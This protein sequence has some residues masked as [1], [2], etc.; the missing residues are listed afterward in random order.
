MTASNAATADPALPAAP[1]KPVAGGRRAPEQVRFLSQAI[2]L[3]E[4][5]PPRA[6]R[7]AVAFGTV[8][9]VGAVAWAGATHVEK[10][11]PTTG[12]ILPS[13]M[14]QSVQHLEGGIVQQLLVIEGDL[15]DQGQVV[16][17]LDPTGARGELD[18]LR[19]RE[20]GLALQVERLRAFA[21]RRSPSLDAGSGP[22]LAADQRAI[23]RMQEQ[24][25][26]SQRLVLDRQLAARRAEL[27][28]LEEQRA[29]LDKQIKIVNQ[30]LEMRGKL[31]EQGLTSRIIYLDTERELARLRGELAQS[32]SNIRRARE[33]VAEAE[34]RLLETEA[35]LATDS[36]NEMGR[37]SAE[38][39]QVR[40]AIARAED[41]VARLDIRSPVR[42]IVKD[43]R[44]RTVGGVVQPGAVVMDIVPVGQELIAEVR[45]SPRD[46]GHIRTGQDVWAKVSAFDF[47]RYG[48][49]PGVLKSFSA[50][51]FQDPQ[52]GQL[53]YRGIVQLTRA[54]V[55]DRA[56]RNPL[57]PGM[58]VQA[59]IRLGDRSVLEY[60]FTPIYASLSNAMRER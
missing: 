28:T 44:S 42:G 10:I 41:R 33:G 35:R 7:L 52:D 39:A 51:T 3:E 38:L 34:A 17:S 15:V 24:A 29:A 23:F 46:V 16:M 6:A 55:G 31:L 27:G 50:T 32:A 13:G 40:E 8:L 45:I 30:A 4:G 60:L 47:A 1:S 54:Y 49:V 2:A 9:F 26:D 56:D 11:A 53:Y 58:I 12:Q 19:A 59:D 25:R 20:H 14:I 37:L 21:E 5:S 36:L 18:Q 43:M 48:A 22:G 57:M